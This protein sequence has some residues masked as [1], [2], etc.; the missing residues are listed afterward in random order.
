MEPF[1]ANYDYTNFRPDG[2]C[3]GR[4]H[5]AGAVLGSSLAKGALRPP[6]DEFHQFDVRP[7]SEG[8][9]SGGASRP[10]QWQVGGQVSARRGR[11]IS[12]GRRQLLG[13]GHGQVADAAARGRQVQGSADHSGGAA[14]GDPPAALRQPSAEHVHRPPQLL[15]AWLQPEYGPSRKASAQPLRSLRTRGRYRVRH[16]ALGGAR[17]RCPDQWHAPRCGRV[18]EL[19]VLRSGRAREVDP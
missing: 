7:T 2:R 9:Q 18:A 17:D 16:A 12:R 5:L 4:G 15:R 14:A 13:G 3:S 8:I 19:H 10:D 1:R 11:A 6:G